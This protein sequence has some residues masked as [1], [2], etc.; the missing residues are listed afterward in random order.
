MRYHDKYFEGSAWLVLG[1]SRFT[2]AKDE[3]HS[4]GIA[5]G[6]V[7]HAEELFVSCKDVVSKV[8]GT[9]AD[10]WQKKCK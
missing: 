10:N 2:K 1:I 3:G 7:N 6:T 5:A 4:M 9:Y 8:P